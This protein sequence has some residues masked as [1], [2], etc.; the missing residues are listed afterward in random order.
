MKATAIGIVALVPLMFGNSPAAARGTRDLVSALCGGGVVVIHL[1][2]KQRAPEFPC[3][4]KA[5][6]AGGTRRF[7]DATQ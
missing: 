2:G 6:H 1:G 7:L 5:C 3:P 4:I